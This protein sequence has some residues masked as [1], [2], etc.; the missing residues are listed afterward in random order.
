MPASTYA[1]YEDPKK[2]KRTFLDLTL[3]KRLAPIFAERGVSEAETLA[4]AGVTNE[5]TETL[6]SIPQ[7]EMPVADEWVEVIG[8]VQ[9]GVW[10][11]Q[12]DWTAGERYEVNFGPSCYPG[13]ERFGLRMDG[14]SMNRTIPPGSD[15]ECLRVGF[16]AIRPDAGSLVIVARNAHDLVELTCKRLD[17]VGDDWVLRCESFEP[18]FQDIIRI[19]QPDGGMFTDE[20]IRV[21]GLVVSAKQDLGP[22]GLSSRRYRDHQPR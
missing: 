17:K 12:S 9:A 5:L 15:L 21:V 8:S 6:R 16:S 10:R 4:L 11:E 3:A 1:A 18:E 2:S 19:G 14:L 22:P 13:K 7:A 20:E